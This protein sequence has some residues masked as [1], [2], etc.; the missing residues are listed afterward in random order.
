MLLCVAMLLTIMPTYAFAAKPD[1]VAATKAGTLTVPGG[2]EAADGFTDGGVYLITAEGKDYSNGTAYT[3]NSSSRISN[4][5]KSYGWNSNGLR[6]RGSGSWNDTWVCYDGSKFATQSSVPSGTKAVK[7]IDKTTGSVVTSMQASQS[8]GRYYVVNSDGTKVLN[9][10]IGTSD[11]AKDVT[12]KTYGLT[13]AFSSNTAAA[14]E[15]TVADSKIASTNG[16]CEWTV[17]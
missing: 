17:N 1:G 5:S 13:N 9:G 11:N 15:L 7:L 2:Y 16:A 6:Q 4:N 14:V 8:T 3:T 12:A 10:N